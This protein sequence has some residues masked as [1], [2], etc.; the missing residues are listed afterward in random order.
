[1][2][3]RPQA[4]EVKR[5]VLRTFLDLGAASPSLFNLKE[6]ILADGGRRLARTYRADDLRAVWVVDEGIVK[7]Y[8]IEGRLLRIVNLLAEKVPQLMVA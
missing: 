2:T 8:D 4:H 1:M 3:V 6:T 5:L 7:V